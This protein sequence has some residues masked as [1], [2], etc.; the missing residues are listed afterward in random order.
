MTD[1]IPAAPSQ[2]GLT[3]NNAAALAYLTIIP[4]IIFLV[5]EP[6]NRN[7]F[8][9]F[10]A[11]QNIFFNIVVFAIWVVLAVIGIIASFTVFLAPVML[12]L[13][14]LFFVG[15]VVAWIIL[16]VKALGGNKF[17]FPVIGPLADKQA[18]K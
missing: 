9:K 10:H 14:L 1:Q 2:S 18:S 12:L 15:T 5:I 8:I 7:P 13:H 6:Y 11:W 4:A 16:V 17:L 3:D